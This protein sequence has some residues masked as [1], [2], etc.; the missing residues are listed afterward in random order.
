MNNFR[1]LGN[2]FW[3]KILKF[4]NA[5]PGSGM[6]KFR[7]RDGNNSDPGGKKI[8]SGIIIPDPQ[9]SK[10]CTYRY[11]AGVFLKVMYRYQSNQPR[12]VPYLDKIALRRQCFA[13]IFQVLEVLGLVQRGSLH[14]PE[15]GHPS[16]PVQK[17]N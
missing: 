2:N 9:H 1:E 11:I 14:V 4:F 12:R 10:R 6:E 17:C 16:E 5:D 3:I 8:V 7:I 15:L 13:E